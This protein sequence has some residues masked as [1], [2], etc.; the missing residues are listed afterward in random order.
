MNHNTLSI[1][2]F[3]AMFSDEQTALEWFSHIR[4]PN[5][6]C[7]PH[8]GSN[9]TTECKKPQPCRCCDCRRH[10][11]VSTGTVMNSSKISARIW[12]YAIY[13]MS[14]SKKRLSSLQLAKLSLEAKR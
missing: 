10:F 2:Q 11:S 8:C 3:H 9:N 1:F 6:R 13:L 14:V 7:C 12:L 4:W 5:G